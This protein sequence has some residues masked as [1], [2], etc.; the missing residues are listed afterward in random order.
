MVLVVGVAADPSGPVADYKPDFAK[1]PATQLYADELTINWGYYQDYFLVVEGTVECILDQYCDFV[2]THGLSKV[3]LINTAMLDSDKKRDL[4]TQCRVSC[5]ATIYGQVGLA[6]F[7]A[8]QAW[9]IE[10]E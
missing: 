3:V 10:P 1:P 8:R 6:N 9:I 5:V 4:A 7:T 2:P